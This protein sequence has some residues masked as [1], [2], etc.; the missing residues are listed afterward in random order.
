MI[1]VRII[2]AT[3]NAGKIREIKKIFSSPDI[4]IISMGE[5]GIDIDVEENGKTFEE[6]AL[7][8]ARAISAMCNDIVLA[9]D[10]GLCVDALGGAPGIYSARYAGEGASD[11]D[12][13][14]KLLNE[15]KDA[16]NRKAHFI[17]VIA[18]VFPDGREFTTKGIVNGKIAYDVKGNQGFGYDPVFFADELGKTFGEAT[19]EEKNR[20]SHRARALDEMYKLIIQKELI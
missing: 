5:I 3:Q 8:K 17:S 12:K 18:L 4:Q 1:L 14:N 6:N 7:I 16:T 9:D 2:A 13:I 20:I 10:S 19:P 11:E 15:L